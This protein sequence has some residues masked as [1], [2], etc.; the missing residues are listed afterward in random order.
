MLDASRRDHA[1][2]S[3]PPPAASQGSQGWPRPPPL[4][5]TGAVSLV[6][7]RMPMALVFWA[8]PAAPPP[9]PPSPF[10]CFPCLFLVSFVRQKL[11][12]CGHFGLASR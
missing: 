10:D 4:A 1:S 5:L 9:P 8:I 3:K 6:F 2:S 12:L 7:G 11:K